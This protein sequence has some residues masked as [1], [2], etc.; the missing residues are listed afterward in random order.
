MLVKWDQPAPTSGVTS[1][2]IK[3]YPSATPSAFTTRSF[4]YPH[5]EYGT[6]DYLGHGFVSGLAMGTN[7]CFQVQARDLGG[8]QSGWAPAV[9]PP[10]AVV[11][12]TTTPG[13]P[14]NVTASYYSTNVGM[15]SSLDGKIHL[16][17]DEL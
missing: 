3:F 13:A 2:V 4:T 16:N 14:Q 1:Y 17:W 15:P 10:C 11:T 12:N 8:N 7:Y 5:I 9:S 6:V